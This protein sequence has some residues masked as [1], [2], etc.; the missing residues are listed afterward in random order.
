M[1]WSPKTGKAGPNVTLEKLFNCTSTLA[2]FFV[3]QRVTEFRKQKFKHFNLLI[4]Y[5]GFRVSGKL[6]LPRKI[7]PPPLWLGLEFGSRLELVLG[8][9]INQT[10][11]PKENSPLLLVL[12]FGLGLVLG[13]G[14]IF[15]GGNCPRTL[16][17]SNNNF[18]P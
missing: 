10:I 16:I 18:N 17:F 4:F 11:A 2:C 8:L 9:R 5:L 7:A 13:L 15:L 1:Q 12:G 6:P 14:A 3:V